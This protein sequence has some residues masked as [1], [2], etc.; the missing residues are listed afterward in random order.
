[1]PPPRF[2]RVGLDELVGPAQV[3][4]GTPCAGAALVPAVRRAA[5]TGTRGLRRFL[6]GIAT[7]AVVAGVWFGAG[8]LVGLRP[9]PATGGAVA[10]ASLMAGQSYV[11]RPGDTL[12][13]IALRFDPAG[14][15]RPI[16]AKLAAELRGNVL[17][18]GDRLVLP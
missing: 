1:M 13:S 17:Q 15:P 12:W 4:A 5:S 6:P 16:V 8:S 9:A 11:A 10:G 7:L 18:P 14:D 3:A 2:D